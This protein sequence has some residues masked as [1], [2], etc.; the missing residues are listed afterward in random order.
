[1][2]IF[3]SFLLNIIYFL[4]IYYGLHD[5]IQP[6]NRLNEQNKLK[7]IELNSKEISSKIDKFNESLAN[8]SR[9]VNHTKSMSSSGFLSVNYSQENPIKEKVNKRKSLE[10]HQPLI[11]PNPTGPVSNSEKLRILA[12]E[13]KKKGDAFLVKLDEYLK[14]FQN[15]KIN[16]NYRPKY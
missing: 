5:K 12:N 8:S 14:T 9:A 6:N 13:R 11:T 15:A 1:M 3:E 4:L 16:N 7:E 2:K 10:N